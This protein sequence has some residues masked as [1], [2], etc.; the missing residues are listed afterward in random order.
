MKKRRLCTTLLS[1]MLAM[2][3]MAGCGAGSQG[4]GSDT[5][6]NSGE[7]KTQLTL[8]IW[9]ED[10]LT[11]N[12]KL[13]EGYKAK[14]EEKF[15]NVEVI[16]AYYKYAPDT[17]V[18]MA[19]AGNLPVI[20]DTWYTEPQ[21]LIKGGYVADITDILKE[22]GW[23]DSMNPQI[24][25][26]LSDKD[27]RVYGLPRDGYALGVM[28]NVE[29]F[30]EAGLVD[31]DGRPIVPKTWEELAKTGQTIK[32]KTGKAG[33]CLLGKD[34]GAG[35]HFSNIAW[36]YGATL[37]TQGEDGKYTANLAS[38]EAIE[39]MEYV[40]DLKWKY[41]CLT[42]DPTNEDWGTG[43]ANLGAGSAAMY[44]AANDAVDQP[45]EKN[46][47]PVEDLAMFAMPAGPKGQYSLSG[48][49]P[50]MFS[51]N[52]TKE[53]INAALDYLEIMGKAPVVTDEAKAGMEAD[54][55]NKVEHGVPVIKDFPAWI[56]QEVLD[57]K[58]KAIKD[59]NNV[60]EKL[61]ESYFT[62]LDKKGNLHLE[63]A[64]STQDMYAELTKVIQAAITDKNA[65]I[66]T[67]MKQANDNYQ[68]ILD[69]KLNK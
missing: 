50:Y 10:T 37:T 62:A 54:A 36:A 18:P 17:F 30:K 8:G 39:A 34:N 2:T 41:D 26:I 3:L 65:D 35:W 33:L 14:M 55:K 23:L 22:R 43:F 29:L 38:K 16:P 40:K 63:E 13:H 1:T 48:G 66:P 51:K 56:N 45:T 9:P 28:A 11:A 61:Y 59:N 57:A 24:K 12:I 19:E 47:L 52:A 6:A 67:L 32:E 49:T 64:G 31:S 53:Q 21:K 27:G 7:K 4:T 69:E 5:K 44:I 58:A 68:K 15:P 20:F 25:Q 46:G 42:A 60:D